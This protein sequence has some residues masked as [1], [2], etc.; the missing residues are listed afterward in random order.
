MPRSKRMK[1]CLENRMKENRMIPE[2]EA[3]CDKEHGNSDSA[4]QD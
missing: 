1:E 2:I 4:H 3:Y